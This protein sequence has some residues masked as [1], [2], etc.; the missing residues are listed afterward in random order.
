MNVRIFWVRAMKCM[1]AQTRP[2][3]ILSSERVFWGN[4]LEP[5]FT[6][7]EKSP[8]P[9]NVPRGGSNPWRCEQ[10]ALALPTEL[11][12]PPYTFHSITPVSGQRLYFWFTSMFLI[13]S[14]QYYVHPSSPFSSSN[15]IF[16]L[17]RSHSRLCM[18]FLSFSLSP[19]KYPLS[20]FDWI[21]SR[22]WYAIVFL[23]LSCFCTCRRK[24]E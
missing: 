12:R 14:C 9:E 10:R 23:I 1:C 20:H 5:M 6:P 13:I 3:F 15:A 24:I 11:F 18:I 16:Q 7:R 22:P 19:D 8:L 4:E 17:Q 21:N 2:R